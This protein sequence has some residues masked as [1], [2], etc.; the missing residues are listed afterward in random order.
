MISTEDFMNNIKNSKA[1]FLMII[2][3]LNFS[4][5]L[6]AIHVINIIIKSFTFKK[7]SLSKEYKNYINIF[8]AKK[9]IKHNKLEDAKHLINFLSEK[10]LSYR[11]IYNLSV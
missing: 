8:S 2:N 10:N 3:Q 6:H 9:I 4:E 11:L 7:L 5:N 1:T